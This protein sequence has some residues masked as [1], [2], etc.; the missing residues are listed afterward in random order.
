MNIDPAHQLASKPISQSEELARRMAYIAH[1]IRDLAIVALEKGIASRTLR[2]LY[3]ASQKALLP[4][5]TVPQF[6]D[7]FAQALVYGLFAA[8]YTHTDAMAFSRQ[9]AFRS[10]PRNNSF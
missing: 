1:N 8:R 6:A 9:S 7:I 5:L 10:L 2:D 3:E 4:N